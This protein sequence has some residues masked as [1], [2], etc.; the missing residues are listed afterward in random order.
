MCL[1]LAGGRELGGADAL[2]EIARRI[3]WAWPLFAL[4]QLP[5]AM[6]VLRAGYR[7]FAANR[8]CLRGA[9]RRPDGNPFVTWLPLVVLPTV[10]FVFRDGLSPWMFMWVMAFTLYAGCKWLTYREAVSQFLNPE[11]LRSAWYLLLWP[12]MGAKQF[13]DVDARIAKP[14]TT[15]WLFAIGKTLVGAV[16][17]WLGAR[18][19]PLNEEMLIGWCGMVGIGLI[20]HFGLFHLLSLAWRAAGVNAETLMHNPARAVSLAGFWGRRWNTAFHELVHRFMFR[21]LSKRIGAL[22]A[23]LLVFLLSGMVHELVISVPARAGYG[24]PTGYFLI[25]GLGISAERTRF[26]RRLGLGRGV[27]GWSF[28]MFIAIL[29]AG[30]LFHPPFIRNVILPMLRAIGAI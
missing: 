2:V 10:V 14:P 29:P 28:T 20:L 9:C 26:G 1:Q 16:L 11:P 18:L 13:L 30:C 25:Q 23:T 8:H 5:G 6:L 22:S 24:L 4:A 17:I 27:R 21:A 12:G 3:W 19:F 7:K 15:E